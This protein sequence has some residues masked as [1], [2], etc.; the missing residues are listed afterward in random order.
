MEFSYVWLSMALIYALANPAVRLIRANAHVKRVQE[1]V[2]QQMT[3]QVKRIKTLVGSPDD[4]GDM[5]EQ[6]IDH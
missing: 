1:Q 3:E 6:L 5:L 4:P 2:Q